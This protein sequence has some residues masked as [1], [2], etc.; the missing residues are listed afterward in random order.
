MVHFIFLS[1]SIWKWLFIKK[2]LSHTYDQC[3]KINP[4]M[5]WKY[6]NFHMFLKLG[7]IQCC[8]CKCQQLYNMEILCKCKAF[9]FTCGQNFYTYTYIIVIYIYRKFFN[10]HLGHAC[11]VLRACRSA[12]FL[13]HNAKKGCEFKIFLY[14]YIYIYIFHL[15]ETYVNIYPMHLHVLV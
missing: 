2:K 1:F 9:V 12:T 13:D 8:A 3:S 5:T 6:Q 11:L 14:I 7:P 10:S 15:L 4:F